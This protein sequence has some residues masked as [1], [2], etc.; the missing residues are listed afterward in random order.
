MIQEKFDNI[1]KDFPIFQKKINK[2]E[3]VFFDNAST[4]QKPQTV[5]DSYKDYYTNIN[6][7]VKRGS[8]YL[9]E[10]SS[11]SYE[12]TRK[13]IQKYIGARHAHECIFTTG[14][15][16]SINL[17][18]HSFGYLL[19]QGDE[20]II[21][22]AEHHANII[23][24]LILSKRK[25]IKI[26][27]LNIEKG[28]QISL[29]KMQKLFSSKTKLLAISHI[30]NVLGIVNPVKEIVKIAHGNNIPVFLDGAQAINHIKIDMQDLNCDFYAFS[31]HKMFGPTGIGLLYG[32]EKWLEKMPP[33][34]TGGEMI[35]KLDFKKG[36]V[37][38]KLPN[39]FEA[40]TM[41]IAESFVWNSAIDYINNINIEDITLYENMLHEYLYEKLK[42]IKGLNIVGVK[43]N[44]ISLMSFYIK[45]IH[46]H[47]IGTILDNKGI[48]IR[49]GHLC[50]IP[51]MKFYKV[52]SL[53]RVSLSIYNNKKE[54]DV[55]A[56]TLS[57]MKKIFR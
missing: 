47:D 16:E 42:N 54:I 8:Y 21:T 36:I 43:N 52:D 5:I 20:I 45:N 39:K 15:T 24:W 9:G 17:L 4:T 37:Y 32:K 30:S 26:K 53:S 28:G 46:S 10:L 12:N 56:E 3:L 13:K 6:A 40:G 23:P 14:T 1:K 51:L 57:N 50:A 31:A 18:A 27:I 11:F 7:N 34:K 19:N 55:L 38:R 41:P 48:S 25:N 44:K 2:K 29:D 33:Y 22:N 49:T 35:S